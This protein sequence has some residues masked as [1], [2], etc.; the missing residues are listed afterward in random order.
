MLTLFGFD[1][2]LG[3]HVYVIF[4]IFFSKILILVQKPNFHP[5]QNLTGSEKWELLYNNEIIVYIYKRL[6]PRKKIRN[7][8]KKEQQK[9]F[10]NEIE[11][12]T[13]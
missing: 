11:H 8:K 1:L 13:S 4:S 6:C 5:C 10:I 2:V 9:L 3:L 7:R 12:Q